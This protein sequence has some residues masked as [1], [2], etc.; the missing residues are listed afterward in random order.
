M[1][2]WTFKSYLS[3]KHQIYS[4]TEL[5]KRIV[6]KTG[7]AISVAQLC[8]LVNKT[9]AMLRFSTM[10][11]ICTALACELNDFVQIGPKTMNPDKPRKLSFKNTPK[12]KIGTK[13]FPAPSDYEA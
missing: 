6:K 3:S 9:P 5:Q 2:K 11:I 8:K 12:S 10:E 1:V 7:V 4:A 13:S